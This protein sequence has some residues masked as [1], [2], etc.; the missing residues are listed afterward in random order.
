MS[1]LKTS[2]FEPTSGV[3]L[4]GAYSSMIG[5]L[6]LSEK[7][8]ILYQAAQGF[9]GGREALES[10][11]RKDL[12]QL[13]CIEM[14]K[15]R[16]Y[17]GVSKSKMVE[18]LLKLVSMKGSRE[19]ADS[20]L[21]SPT[22][23]IPVPQNSCRRQR[24]AGRPA[25]V[26]SAIQT[27]VDVG[28]QK[29]EP[30]WVC[31]NT[32]CKAQLLQ[33][34]SFCQRCS[35][36]ICKK[37]DDNKDP[38]LWIV[39]TPEPLKETDCRLSCHIECALD[40]DIAG[41][42]ADGSDV[43]LDGSYR[44]RSCGKISNLIGS[45]KKQLV[46]AKDARRVDTLCQRLSLSYR[47]L[48]GTHKHKALHEL[49]ERAIQKLEAEVGSITEG[50]A[51]FARGL[52]NRLSSSSE[53]LELVILALEKADALDE[54]LVVDHK[55]EVVEAPAVE[56]KN[57]GM[58]CTIEFNNVSSSSIVL[59]VK[60]GGELVTGY[61][62]WHRKACDPTFANN[63]TCIITANPGRAQISSL[64]ACTEYAFYVVPFS[65]RG[66]GEP[67]EA[68]FFTKT[69]ELQLPREECQD[70]HLITGLN[71]VNA[72]EDIC[73]S[74]KLES[75]FKVRELGKVLHSAW[76]EE[77]Q[78]AHVR[79]G[80]FRGKGGV[81]SLIDRKNNEEKKSECM[82]S[83]LNVLSSP[84]ADVSNVDNSTCKLS[85]EKAPSSE[86]NASVNLDGGVEESRVTVEVELA[87]PPN[88]TLSR[89]DSSVLLQEVEAKGQTIRA[90]V[91]D[92]DDTSDPGNSHTSQREETEALSQVVSDV[93]QTN[94][95][96]ELQ[97]VLEDRRRVRGVEST[98][99]GESWA[100]QVRSAGTAI[101]M[102]PQTA[103]MRKRTSEGLGRGDSYGLVNGCGGS[104]GGPLCAARNYEFCV[105]IVRWL[106]C[107]GY[108]KED[109][110]MKFLTWFSLKASEHEK[111]VVSVFIDTLQDNPASLA[112]QL[113]D[114]FSDIISS[115][116]HH[117]VSNG[118]R[119]KL[120]H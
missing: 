67:A 26:P 46:I 101:G 5:G 96:N 100:V 72:E 63:P 22:S 64:Q 4:S 28:T 10:W 111:R 92:L 9:K 45:W 30:S 117:T 35:C 19:K 94:A 51:K 88:R 53:V 29:A 73:I 32:A 77:F 34:V 103:I 18:H 104:V 81:K 38:S 106:E 78:S 40:N 82:S 120:W 108:L 113:V 12:L 58:V 36:C 39:C 105:K 2:Q 50:S 52:V 56:E 3:Y 23:Q 71:V 59:T 48:N 109:F 1:P 31:R 15:E 62:L 6:S 57:A 89:R 116:R 98:G 80:I 27:P 87:P 86:V 85:P 70:G 112:G 118:F 90:E 107:E 44:C 61:R 84:G 42:V 97:D 76:A 16:K 91:T 33:G 47:L 65:E 54:E 69:A 60:G 17:T 102:E 14:G 37:F 11:T 95:P 7:Q 41:V 68:R 79:K 25:R 20:G 110:R 119:N 99:H 115:K 93:M 74:D 8:E 43:L 13:I 55:A 21:A 114:T 24:K 75:N 49:V 66:I 83:G